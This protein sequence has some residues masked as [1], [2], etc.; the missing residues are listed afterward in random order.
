MN[1]VTE[2]EIKIT[3]RPGNYNSTHDQT[4]EEIIRELES[5]LNYQFVDITG[6]NIDEIEI[7]VNR[8]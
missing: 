4:D 2:I 6:H 3:I 1:K 5:D 7:E 8:D